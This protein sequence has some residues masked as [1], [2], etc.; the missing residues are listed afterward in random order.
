MICQ[1]NL[2]LRGTVSEE[3]E[4]LA[5]DVE[6]ASAN[7]ALYR[8]GR[9]NHHAEE[10]VIQLQGLLLLIVPLNDIAVQGKHRLGFGQNHHT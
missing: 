10:P 6:A 4:A 7:A 5:Y 3:S 1:Y 9:R 8:R 2:F